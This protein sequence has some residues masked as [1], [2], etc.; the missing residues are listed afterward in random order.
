MGKQAL[1]AHWAQEERDA[2]RTLCRATAWPGDSQHTA[3]RVP[4][5]TGKED[6]RLAFSAGQLLGS[7]GSFN[8]DAV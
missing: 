7:S 4:P 5:A 6:R 1:K 3:C 2:V 8:I